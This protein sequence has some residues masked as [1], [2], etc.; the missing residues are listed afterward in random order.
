MVY[1]QSNT[2]HTGRHCCSGKN[3]FINFWLRFFDTR[4]E[5]QFLKVFCNHTM[6]TTP[7]TFSTSQSVFA[8][9]DLKNLTDAATVENSTNSLPTWSNVNLQL[10]GRTP[11]SQHH[12]RD[13]KNLTDAATVENSTNSL[14]TRSNVNLQLHGR[15]PTSQHYGRDLKN[16]TDAATVENSTNSLPTWS[17]VN[18]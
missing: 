4:R 1:I 12:G 11:T 18:L 14:P 5:T 7:P 16:L 2:N 9:R 8:G 6:L 3:G 15:A 13:L 17:N 10:H